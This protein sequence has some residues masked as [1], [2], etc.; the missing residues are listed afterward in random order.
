MNEQTNKHINKTVIKYINKCKF[1]NR[2]AKF[3]ANYIFIFMYSIQMHPCKGEPS[4]RHSDNIL[5][6]FTLD[7]HIFSMSET[8]SCQKKD[9]LVTKSL[10][11]ANMTRFFL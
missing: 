4:I 1:E 10:L 6:I 3:A 2:T 11:G 9:T 8:Q 5:M 7:I